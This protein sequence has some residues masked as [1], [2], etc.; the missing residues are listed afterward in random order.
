MPNALFII[1][2]RFGGKG[3]LRK[4]QMC[5]GCGKDNAD[6]LHLKFSR[7]GELFYTEYVAAEKYQGYPGIL[8]GGIISTIL[9]EVMANILHVQGLHPMTADLQ[10]RFQQPVPI[11]Q[12]IRYI[13]KI[14]SIRKRL[15]EVEGWVELPD[16]KVAA[17]ATAKMLV[18][19]GIYPGNNIVE[20]Q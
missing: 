3:K 19:K 9:D 4:V 16:G 2:V 1:R 13:S 12:K 7:E 10:I 14:T 11:G 6:G 15:C 8:Q 17:R 18:T 5:F 20:D